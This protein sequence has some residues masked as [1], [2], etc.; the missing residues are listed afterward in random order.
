MIKYFLVKIIIIVQIIQ[1]LKGL[2]FEIKTI[3]NEK[4]FRNLNSNSQIY[5]NSH[6]LNYYYTN[7]YLGKLGKK[8]SYLLDTGSSI[9]SSPCNLC[10]EC[11]NHKNNYFQI[12]DENILKCHDDKCTMVNNNCYDD[13]NNCSFI[14]TYLDSSHLEGIYV[15]EIVRF[16]DNYLNQKINYIP[17]G[18][19]IKETHFFKKQLADGI[20]GLSNSNKNFITILKNHGIIKKNIFSICLSQLGGY[21]TIEEINNKH[22]LS[23]QILYTEMIDYRYYIINVTSITINNKSINVLKKAIIDSGTTYTYFPSEITNYLIKIIR[24]ICNKKCGKFERKRE[25]GG[26]FYFRNNEEMLYAINNIFPNIT[27]SINNEINY[28][29][30]PQ[31]YYYNFSLKENNSFCLGFSSDYEN[32]ILGSTWMKGYDIIFDREDNKIGFVVSNC[33]FYNNNGEEENVIDNN[34][35]NENIID[36]NICDNFPNSIFIYL[37]VCGILV[38]IL[39]MFFLGICFLRRGNN[40]LWIKFEKEK[41][42]MNPNINIELNSS[43]N[44]TSNYALFSSK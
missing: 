29:W 18:C 1:K 37:F 43:N 24:Q 7:L 34:Y 27:F 17:I 14:V 10:L 12:L 8:Q 19:T 36:K 41:L 44:S 40:F 35:D 33:N 30:T 9:T 6:I 22:H 25:F 5:G 15:N 28:I 20:M 11:G 21:F 23:N 13:N 16:G 31:N 26:C 42:I 3:K 39:I 32:F 2:T 4:I 38:A